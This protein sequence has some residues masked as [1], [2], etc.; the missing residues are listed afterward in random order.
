MAANERQ[1][2]TTL[3]E[4]LVAVV[5]LAVCASGILA[6][7][8]SSR[9]NAGYAG[10]RAIALATATSVIEGARSNAANGALVV[11]TSGPIPVA[12]IPAPASYICTVALVAGYTD[13]YEVTVNLTWTESTTRGSRGDSLQLVT[14]LRSPG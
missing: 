4:L 3:A 7:L 11:G 1:R 13:L 10:R 6:C 2:G 12:G 9:H 5:F 8:A 14:R